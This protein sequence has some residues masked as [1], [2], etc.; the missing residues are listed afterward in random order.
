MTPT[1]SQPPIQALTCDPAY[2]ID[3]D[4]TS[5]SVNKSTLTSSS[6]LIKTEH[7]AQVL[8]SSSKDSKSALSLKIEMI[9]EVVR[10]LPV[11]VYT[12][13]GYSE[14]SLNRNRTDIN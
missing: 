3:S 5:G 7:G 11:T 9:P 8:I 12:L 14:A 6:I 4:P 10:A 13:Q 1:Y 2:N